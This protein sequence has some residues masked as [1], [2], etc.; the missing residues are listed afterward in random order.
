MYNASMNT[1]AQKIHVINYK[2]WIAIYSLTCS[3]KVSCHVN[4]C[5]RL[6]PLQASRACLPELQPATLIAG[7]GGRRRPPSPK[8]REISPP[9]HWRPHPSRCEG[10]SEWPAWAGGT[11]IRFERLPHLHSHEATAR[12]LQLSQR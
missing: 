12:K 1:V 7:L 5:L 2:T 4:K 11:R 10:A 8:P 3:P 9:R 6:F